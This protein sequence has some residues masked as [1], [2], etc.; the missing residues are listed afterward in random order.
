MKRLIFVAVIVVYCIF[1]I[2]L[3]LR[4]LGIV[5][6]LNHSSSY[7]AII[8]SYFAFTLAFYFGTVDSELKNFICVTITSVVMIII[9]FFLSGWT[10]WTSWLALLAIMA[11]GYF[12]GVKWYLA[13]PSK[14]E[15]D[16][17]NTPG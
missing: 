2:E 16:D 1:T 9:F 17:C 15:L 3:I 14:G 6:I 4:L 8:T 11:V 13:C 10:N 5:S 7:S 12:Y